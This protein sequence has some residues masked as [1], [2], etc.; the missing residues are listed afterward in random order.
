M[1]LFMRFLVGG[2]GI[3]LALT[4]A[5]WCS[6][7]KS[8]K[9]TVQISGVEDEET[10]AALRKS[11]AAVPA[12]KL[13]QEDLQPADQPDRAKNFFTKPFALE[14]T[15]LS[16]IDLGA[17]AKAVAQTKVPRKSER[18]VWLNLVL[19]H[20]GQVNEPEIVALRE[21]VADCAGVEARARGGIGGNVQAS[22]VWIR[23]DASGNAGLTDIMNA[24]KKAKLDLHLQKP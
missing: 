11:L 20:A 17:V 13:K 6:E 2:V 10:A 22:T 23:L 16:K 1:R 8:A 7:L 5:S 18:G 24:V 19:H 14:L 3:A 21:A 12:L 4:A 9:I 15:D